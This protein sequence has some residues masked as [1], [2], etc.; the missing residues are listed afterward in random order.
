[1]V[2][3]IWK[4]PSVIVK[5][6]ITL[7][8]KVRGWG[9]SNHKLLPKFPQTLSITLYFYCK[10]DLNATDGNLQK[11]NNFYLH[12]LEKCL[13]AALKI[14]HRNNLV[15]VNFETLLSENNLTMLYENKRFCTEFF[16]MKSKYSLRSIASDL[17]HTEWGGFLTNIL[18][19]T[20]KL[21]TQWMYFS[22]EIVVLTVC[23]AQSC[24]LLNTRQQKKDFN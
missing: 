17:E 18:N 20:I 11:I 12:F 16:L 21:E 15:N 14:S 4:T 6:K 7:Q 19:R 1:M 23:M 13:L 22:D 8:Q 24:S 5:N 9:K 2:S 10:L 3:N